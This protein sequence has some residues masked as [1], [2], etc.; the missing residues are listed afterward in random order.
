MGETKKPTGEVGFFVFDEFVFRNAI[1]VV[2]SLGNSALSLSQH[3][4][5]NRYSIKYQPMV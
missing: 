4:Q 3:H 1:Y 2:G 5:S